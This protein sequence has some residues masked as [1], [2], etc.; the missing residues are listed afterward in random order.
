M[1]AQL[2][3]QLREMTGL[4]SDHCQLCGYGLEPGQ[5][6]NEDG[7]LALVVS[8]PGDHRAVRLELDG[9]VFQLFLP[10][11][12]D[13]AECGHTPEGAREALLDVLA[14]LDAYANPATR[15]VEV[16]R[17]LRGT[18]RELHVSNGAILRLRG[19]NSGPVDDR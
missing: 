1:T 17:F 3:P 9:E 11:G 15:E 19:L 8:L 6:P 7:L 18:R 12:Y 14:F 5:Q 13:W 2:S 16:H 10:G 4:I